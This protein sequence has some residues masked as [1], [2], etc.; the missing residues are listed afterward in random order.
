MQPGPWNEDIENLLTSCYQRAAFAAQGWH[1]ALARRLPALHFARGA[2]VP[3]V[4]D[5][6]ET[7][8][9]GSAA[10]DVTENLATLLSR[11]RPSN[12]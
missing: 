1:G 3:A 8:G 7:G 6:A 10:D 9:T 12:S 4:T 2:S 5:A 11:R